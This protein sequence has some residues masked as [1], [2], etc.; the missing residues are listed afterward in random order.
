MQILTIGIPLPNSSIDNNNVLSAPSYF[1]YQALV[2][3]PE[4]ITRG[5][6]E[7]LDDG[8]K[9]D[10]ADGRP[11]VNGATT[12]AAVSAADQLKRR[13]DETQ[14][15]LEA[16]GT[17]VVFGRPNA[18]L[19][20]V[21]GFEGCDRYTWLPAPEGAAWSHPFM[22]QAEGV[23][24]R[25]RDD[26]HPMAEVL[27]EFRKNVTYR[28]AFDDRHPAFRDAHVIAVGGADMPI[29]VQFDI[30]AGRVIF[31]PA[32]KI[33]GSPARSRLA[34]SLVSAILQVHGTPASAAAPRWARS[35]A[36][37]GLEQ[38]EAEVE[39]AEADAKEAQ[40]RLD[41][42]RE[43]V[44]AL[45]D[46]RAL[47]WAEGHQFE[48]AV[49]LSLQSIGFT[50]TSKP[51]EPIVA[52]NGDETVFVEH[53]SSR[54]KVVEWPYIRLQ[55][56]LEEALLRR[57]QQPRGLVIVNGIR[58]DAP[59]ER[60]AEFTDPLR[61]A[62]ENYRYGLLTGS[63]LFAMVQRAI[64]GADDEALQTLRRRILRTSGELTLDD[65]LTESDEPT[66]PGTIF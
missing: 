6:R 65:A 26:V 34:H 31:L 15:V 35:L 51:G 29:A 5:T 43:Q 28:V 21:I 39:E 27:R 66:S 50:V 63:T 7:F 16:G 2:V 23:T 4:T 60:K 32:L 52:T 24:V 44:T 64:G 56:R 53:E 12:A 11:V 54:E 37:P 61:I 48:K 20:G 59:E 55:R 8:K 1:D 18:S 47:L 3:D 17:I 58:G 49:R 25:I 41:D 19:S 46:Y 13:T 14:R 22:R 33:T 30:L 57:R 45:T 38:L 36:V 40:S 42:A 62:C 9:F 10:A